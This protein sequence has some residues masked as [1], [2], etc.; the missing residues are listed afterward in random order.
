MSMFSWKNYYLI[1]F[2]MKKL[3]LLYWQPRT[4][5]LIFL[6]KK[7][8]IYNNTTTYV[9]QG[10]GSRLVSCNG[11]RKISTFVYSI[12]RFN[13]GR[14]L[15]WLLND[16]DLGWCYELINNNYNPMNFTQIKWHNE[17]ERCKYNMVIHFSAIV[18][19]FYIHMKSQIQ[20]LIV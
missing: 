6:S 1:H 10:F 20:H 7:F 17:F 16:F 3:T 11:H 4:F 8:S 14:H 18:A 19:I 2:I 12:K 9:R 13:N 5:T 15:I